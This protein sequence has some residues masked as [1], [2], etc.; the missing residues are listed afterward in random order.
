VAQDP[1]GTGSEK[2]QRE[3]GAELS[4]LQELHQS[5][6]GNKILGRTYAHGISQR[7]FQGN[8]ME[9]KSFLDHIAAPTVH[10][11]MWDE[12]HRYRIDYAQDEVAR[13]LHNYV[14]AVMSLVA[15]TRNFVNEH[16]P[17]TYLSREYERRV[18]QDFAENPLHIFI[19][20]LRNYT[21]HYRLPATRAVA[22]LKRRED[23]GT[24]LDNAFKLRVD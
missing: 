15:A 7:V 3:L 21:H 4:R 10:A 14:S 18:R 23:G 22:S 19:Q 20:S 11:H 1:Q 24:D 17:D 2:R 5:S 6:E 12:R 9:L 13:L 8:H 16:Y